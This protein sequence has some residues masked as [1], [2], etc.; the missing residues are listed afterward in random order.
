MF[1]KRFKLFSLLGFDVNID[2]SWLLVVVLITWSLA[3]SL[4]PHF[5]KDLLPATYWWMGLAGALGLFG[6]ILLHEIGHS[7]VARRYGVPIKGITLFIF[8]GVA[9]MEREPTSAKVEFLVAIAGPIVSLLIA[10][11]CYGLSAAGRVANAPVPLVG[12]LSYLAWINLIVVVFNLI[13]AFPL[14]GGRVLRSFLWHVRG[15]LRW[16]TRVTATIGASF[17][18]F[19]VML[20]VFSLIRGNLVGGMW[21]A[22][23]G[24]FL[25][26]AAQMSYQQVLIR[27]ALE[28]EPIHRF[29][30]TAVKAVPPW[31]TIE[32]LVEEYVYTHHHKMYPVVD[33]GQLVGCVTVPAIKDIPRAEWSQRKVADVL[34]P[35]GPENTI[36]PDTDAMQALSQMSRDQVSRLMVVQQGELLGV[37]T[38]KDLMQFISLKV[39]L[40]DDLHPAGMAL[41]D[42]A[43]SRD[44]SHGTGPLNR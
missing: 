14:D 30:Q 44:E 3:T 27:R 6:S 11:V 18:F 19:L 16:A 20:G 42:D 24:M 17:G 28:G 5:H 39:E 13:P 34:Q 41:T 12:V 29:M 21:Q 36:A 40:E 33:D 4:F 32:Q 43:T 31:L 38:L 15:S 9:E 10:A 23:I 22:L 35:C 26:S 7:L 25:R 37:I 8:G 2:L 1:T